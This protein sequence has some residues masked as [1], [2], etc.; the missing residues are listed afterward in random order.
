MVMGND[1]EGPDSRDVGFLEAA[2]ILKESVIA[3]RSSRPARK[4]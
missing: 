3:H 2:I 4:M 1:V